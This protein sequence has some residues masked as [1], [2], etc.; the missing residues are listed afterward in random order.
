MTYLGWLNSLGGVQYWLF[1]GRKDYNIDIYDSGVTRK[2]VFPGW[3]NSYGP[4]A[5]T[6]KQQT[7]RK[8]QRQ[9]VVRTHAIS[10]TAAMELGEQIKSAI[11][12][13]VVTSKRDRITV[14]VDTNSFTIVKE[15]DKMHSLSFTITYTDDLPSQHV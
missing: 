6:I 13:Q 3:P 15:A 2:N 4:T 14:L 9:E 11:L 10:R 1:T 5:D 8:S 7:F 12:V